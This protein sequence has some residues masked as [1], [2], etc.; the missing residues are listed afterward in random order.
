MTIKQILGWFIF[1][2]VVFEVLP[3]CEVLIMHM[4]LLFNIQL[5][6]YLLGTTK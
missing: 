5:F 4:P 3:F 6:Q 2:H 1:Q